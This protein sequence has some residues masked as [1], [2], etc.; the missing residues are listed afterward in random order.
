MAIA[1]LYIHV[2]FCAQKCRYCDFDSRALASVTREDAMDRYF[3]L[4]SARLDDC[5]EAGALTHI[6][7]VY[8]GGGTPSLAGSRLVSLARQITHVC[9]PFEFTC[10]ANPE[11][12]TDG[13]ACALKEVGVTRISLGVQS[14]DATELSAIGRI[15]SAE[16]ALDAIQSCKAAGL[17]VS[18][19]VMCGLPGQT[20]QSW[21]ATLEGIVSARPDHVSVYPLTLEEGTPL[22][23][24][25][26]LDD[27]LEPDED[28]Q[29]DCMD[30][31][32][33]TL[34]R[35]GYLPYEVASYARPG[36]ECRHNIAYWTGR[37][38]L[39]I[40]RSAA[41]MLDRTDFDDMRTLFPHVVPTNDAWRIRLVQ[42]D[43]GGGMFDLECLTRREAMA[44]DLMLA[45]RMTAGVPSRLLREAAAVIPASLVL[46]A[47]ERAVRLG[48][49][50]WVR[51]GEAVPGISTAS[52]IVDPRGLSLA[53]TH[54]GWLDGNVLFELFWGLH[55]GS[56]RIASS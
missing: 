46:H 36:H 6:E 49:A 5:F 34:G 27:S 7:T 35:A 4:L 45:C 1:A 38:Y 37:G 21:M 32:R 17:D 47:C 28:F 22:M 24:A 12:L 50:R 53:P 13:L 54:L 25:A 9:S 51:D 14:L 33:R 11:S 23:R 40:G 8:I 56:G 31:A 18:C 30:A 41:M 52:A 20:A 29:A 26:E 16:R 10:E 55:E 42:T 3:A 19:D 48:L 39:G 43:D 44:E 2:P 15:H